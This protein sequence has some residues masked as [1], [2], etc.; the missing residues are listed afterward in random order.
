MGISAFC[1][2]REVC[3][4]SYGSAV[5]TLFCCDVVVVVFHCADDDVFCYVRTVDADE[6]HTAGVLSGNILIGA[7]IV[8]ET[9]DDI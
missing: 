6:L 9:S 4:L 5:G 1:G 7:E 8:D 2:A 3:A